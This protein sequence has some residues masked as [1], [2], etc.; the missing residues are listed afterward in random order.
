MDLVRSNFQI[1]HMFLLNY[2]SLNCLSMVIIK[3]FL[4]A[5]LYV[6]RPLVSQHLHFNLHI[7]LGPV[8][9]NYHQFLTISK[10]CNNSYFKCEE[11]L[12]FEAC[13]DVMLVNTRP[14]NHHITKYRKPV[15][16]W[17]YCSSEVYIHVLTCNVNYT[18][19]TLWELGCH[20]KLIEA[21]WRIYA[22][23]NYTI[24]GSDNGLSPGGRQ[25]IIWTNA[26]ILLIGPLATNFSEIV[27]EIHTFSF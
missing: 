17:R 27:I 23:L 14:S 12:Q 6:C 16:V 3:L 10:R 1:A 21:E 2:M 4:I 18:H 7:L 22:S 26:G 15:S 9:G 11:C 13:Q 20:L 25:A 5:S 24:T 19:E 8:F